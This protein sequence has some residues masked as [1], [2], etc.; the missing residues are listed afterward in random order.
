MQ[1]FL[2]LSNVIKVLIFKTK[3]KVEEIVSININRIK[4][5]VIT[6]VDDH[7]CH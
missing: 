7:S 3:E 4:V 6:L 2:V 5:S 1:L